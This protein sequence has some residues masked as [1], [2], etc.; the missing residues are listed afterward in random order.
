MRGVLLASLLAAPFVHG[1][2]HE[3][4]APLARR[5][6]DIN[7]FRPPLKAAYTDSNTS[8]IDYVDTA[9]QLVQKTVPGAT[10]R[11]VGD[12][13]VG[14]NGVAHINFKQTANGLDIDNADF[15]VNVKNGKV[16][17]FGNS[18]YTGLIPSPAPIEKRELGHPV[19]ALKGASEVLQ[20]PVTANAATAE[21]LAGKE[22]YTIKGASGVEKDPEARLVY[23]QQADGSLR[24]TWR[25]ETDISDLDNWLL[26]YVDAQTLKDV[27]SVV[28][29]SADASF[30]VYPWGI[31]DPT[32]GPRQVLTNPWDTTASEFG[33]LSTGTTTYTTTR[34]NNGIA[35][36]NPS[37]GTAYLN[38]YRPTNAQSIFQYPYSTTTGTPATYV[39]AA[40]TQLFYTANTYHD[41]LH[42]LGFNE[43]AGNFETNNN[44]QGGVGND[45]VILNVQDGSG[46]NNANFATPPDGQVPRMRM[47]IWT[48]PNPDRDCAFEAGVV[49]HEYTHGLSNRLTGGPANTNCLSALE[50]GGMGEGWG[51]F[52][53]TA[54]RLKAGDT[55]AKNYPMGEWVNN[56]AG[57]RA[58]PYSTSLTTNPL[59]YTSANALNEVHNIGTIWETMLY[60]VLWNLIDKY[61]KNDAPKPTFKNGVP[62][63]GKYLAM[64][65]VIDGMALQPCSPNF[66]QARDAILDAD[67]ALTGGANQCEIWKGF[68]KRGLGSGA[69]YG[70]TRTASTVVPSG[71][72]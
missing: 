48:A 35:Q 37:G 59:T 18:F 6:I 65:L 4:R 27:V 5:T 15:N 3:V 1:H 69:K 58:Y 14:D 8:G 60:E 42:T 56:G 66:V 39:D 24:L 30:Q 49:I 34:G 55:R 21:P 26:T 12:H 64:K 19:D 63:D 11:V 72:C 7:A 17:S 25:V 68:A 50:S 52:M 13:Y 46:T 57:I 47:Y 16:F 38:N 33:W 10:F 53:A 70:T 43:K 31:N 28:D 22:M 29:Y 62:T 36:N 54:I 40:I 45:A 23:F 20:L 9:T 2:P 71:V 51:D 44:G 61:G 32:E 41:L 67:T